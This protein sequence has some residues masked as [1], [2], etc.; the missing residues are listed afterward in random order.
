VRNGLM[1]IAK[2]FLNIQ[3]AP[4]KNAILKLYF[5]NGTPCILLHISITHVNYDK[6][7]IRL[8]GSKTKAYRDIL[9]F[10]FL[11]RPV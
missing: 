6:N 10:K 8:Y 1:H 3:G 2:Y 4:N 5:F 7:D 11:I 9:N